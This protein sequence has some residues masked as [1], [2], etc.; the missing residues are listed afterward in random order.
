VPQQVLVEDD[1]PKLLLI[2][3]LHCCSTASARALLYP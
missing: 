3:C 2:H 1:D